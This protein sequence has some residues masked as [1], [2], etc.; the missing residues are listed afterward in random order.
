MSTDGYDQ[1]STVT[2]KYRLPQDP[3][4]GASL[5]T[6]R[7]RK[8]S[9][10]W[11]IGQDCKDE[12][13][14]TRQ[15]VEAVVLDRK[16]S[17]QRDQEVQQEEAR[18]GMVLGRKWTSFQGEPKGRR[19]TRT[20]RRIGEEERQ[21]RPGTSCTTVRSLASVFHCSGKPLQGLYQRSEAISFILEGSYRLQGEEWTGGWRPVRSRRQ[22]S[23]Q[24]LRVIQTMDLPEGRREVGG[25]RDTEGVEERDGLQR[26]MQWEGGGSDC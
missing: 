6:L 18:K 13:K 22:Q 5:P 20:G 14:L 26:A 25:C 11:R 1:E 2:G 8:P 9:Q 10:K 24:G 7:V 4:A 3:R 16:V 19:Q 21:A 23:G 12:L 17:Q 15:G